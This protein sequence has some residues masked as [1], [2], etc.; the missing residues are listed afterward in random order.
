MR[1]AEPLQRP[2]RPTIAAVRR[3]PHSLR[4]RTGCGTKGGGTIDQLAELADLLGVSRR[5]LRAAIGV[6]WHRALPARYDYDFGPLFVGR[7]GTAVG[8]LC[9]GSD[10]EVMGAGGVS[11]RAATRVIVGGAEAV[12][13]LDGQVGWAMDGPKLSVVRGVGVD[14]RAFLAGLRSAVSRCH[15]GVPAGAAGL[16]LVSQ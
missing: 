1:D 5:D 15:A 8:I 14:P 7:E 4:A 13:R 16:S 12:R 9:L 10:T 6:P 11:S 3:R 2:L